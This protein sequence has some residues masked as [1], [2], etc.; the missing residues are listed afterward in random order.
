MSYITVRNFLVSYWQCCVTWVES[1][2]SLVERLHYQAILGDWLETIRTTIII[3]AI[4]YDIEIQQSHHLVSN[5]NFNQPPALRL[6]DRADAGTNDRPVLHHK[7]ANERA[8]I[9]GLLTTLGAYN[10]RLLP[11]Y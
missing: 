5:H 4:N 3:V 7:S 9:M 1:K 2:L 10:D 11:L 8:A 6:T